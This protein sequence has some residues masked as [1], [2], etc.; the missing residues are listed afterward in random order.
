MSEPVQKS[1]GIRLD[2]GVI[3]TIRFKR[4]DTIIA[5]PV[6]GECNLFVYYKGSDRGNHGAS[7]R[8]SNAA[9]QEVLTTFEAY[10]EQYD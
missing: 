2:N 1:M 5:Y 4:V 6:D 7:L 3:T 8:M 10:I 9:A